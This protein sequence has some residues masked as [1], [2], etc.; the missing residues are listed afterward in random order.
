M[1]FR[2]R[3]FND[4]I[5][6]EVYTSPTFL[7]TGFRDFIKSLNNKGSGSSVSRTL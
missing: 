6:C 7:S 4:S 1:L 2:G 5:G 3:G